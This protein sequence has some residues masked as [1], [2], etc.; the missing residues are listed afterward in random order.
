M[1]LLFVSYSRL[2]KPEQLSVELSASTL[3]RGTTLAVEWQRADG[4]WPSEDPVSP[5]GAAAAGAGGTGSTIRAVGYGSSSSSSGYDDGKSTSDS[6][7]YKP[8]QSSAL[9]YG[10][11]GGYGYGSGSGY[12]IGSTKPGHTGLSNVGNTCFM[13]SALQCLSH[14]PD[15]K[16][17]FVNEG[18]W[19]RELNRDNPIGCGGALAE[20]F[21]ELLEQLWSGRHSTI[22]PREVKR[23][24]AHHA[25]QFSGYAQHDSQ[26]LTAFLLDGLHEDLNRILKKPYVE[27]KE[28]RTAAVVGDGRG[29]EA[30]TWMRLGSGMSGWVCCCLLPCRSFSTSTPTC[31]S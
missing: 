15:L 26:E 16:R 30:R 31:L 8:Q 27:S 4:S 11:S 21:A 23:V 7:W 3:N 20:A 12:G 1:P 6:Q 9:G 13:N 24:V 22:A 18:A 10:S 2:D 14:T 5:K 17:Y 29:K 25:P 28:V 19:R